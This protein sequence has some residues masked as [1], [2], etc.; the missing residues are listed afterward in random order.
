[1]FFEPRRVTEIPQCPICGFRMKWWL[2]KWNCLN[3]GQW[4]G[5]CGDSTSDPGGLWSEPKDLIK[6][7][8]SQDK[9][10]KTGMLC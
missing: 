10:S 9:D 1:M 7:N 4:S 6:K 3:C 5:C 2:A 8:D